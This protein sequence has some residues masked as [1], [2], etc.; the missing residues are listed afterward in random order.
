MPVVLP[1]A[2]T[3]GDAVNAVSGVEWTLD[4]SESNDPDGGTITSYAWTLAAKPP[5][6]SAALTT[7]N[8]VSAKFTP[9]VVGT[10]RFFLV[11]T[12][13]GN[14]TSETTQ[15]KAPSSAFS[16]VSV[17]TANKGMIIPAVGQRDWGD[18][19]HN[20]L[21]SLDDT[22]A[23]DPPKFVFDPNESEP[24]G[25]VYS[26]WAN[27]YADFDEIGSDVFREVIIDASGLDEFEHPT[28]PAGEYDFKNAKLSDG[29]ARVYTQAAL[30]IEGL[31]KIYGGSTTP[32]TFEAGVT[33]T[34]LYSIEGLTLLPPVSGDAPIQWNPGGRQLVVIREVYVYSVV[35]GAP[36][37]FEVSGA[38]S[39][40]AVL[41]IG[42]TIKGLTGLEPIM[43][44]SPANLTIA[45]RS[46][47]EI[48]SNSL[49]SEAGSTFGGNYD[50]TSGIADP[51]A[52]DLPRFLGDAPN[53]IGPIVHAEKIGVQGD[54]FNIIHG[55][56]LQ[57][58]LQSIDDEFGVAPPLSSVLT[59]GNIGDDGQ[60][61][62]V[63]GIEGRQ[64]SGDADGGSL[65]VM[66]GKSAGTGDGGTLYLRGGQPDGG[67]VE[68]DVEIRG[69]KIAL[70]SDT[71]VQQDITLKKGA[72]IGRLS[73][74][75]GNEYEIWTSDGG[76]DWW[77]GHAY[78][79]QTSGDHHD[80]IR[81]SGTYREFTCDSGV[82]FADACYLDGTGKIQQ[83]IATSMATSRVIGFVKEKKG[84]TTCFVQLSGNAPFSGSV[85]AGD[86]AYLSA[87]A[88]GNITNTA[89]SSTGEVVAPLGIGVGDGSVVIQVFP[90]IEIT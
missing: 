84:D 1:I 67:G 62:S 37:L 31:G 17:P 41:M 36:E 5:G 26:D 61:I 28:I 40:V 45:M 52:G 49:A 81:P 66:G 20:A 18:H 33:I 44:R 78:W 59:S 83:A 80:L 51:Q 54:P 63:S 43:I 74:A 64:P 65:K 23:V 12:A 68:G 71:D 15:G 29:G 11:V 72:M 10:Y 53:G 90:E 9:D 88:A 35:S 19:L 86:R 34:N 69:T 85:G 8:S 47:T 16:N 13:T 82:A 75:P 56:N 58:V 22:T 30:E 2:V 24:S 87:S 27:L 4:G 79:T 89:P 7:P 77:D 42:S 32:L 55:D 76:G 50:A 48:G 70:E 38:D 14:K 21:E 25:N 46:G 3:A 73:S 60:V 6:S 39:D 57:E